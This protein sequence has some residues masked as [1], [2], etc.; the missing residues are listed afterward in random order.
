M[1]TYDRDVQSEIRRLHQEK[2]WQIGLSGFGRF[3]KER[4]FEIIVITGLII[5]TF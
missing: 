3:L 1:E 2:R 4:R 5:A